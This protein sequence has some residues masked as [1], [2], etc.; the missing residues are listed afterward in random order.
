MR[1][2]ILLAA[3]GAAVPARADISDSGALTIGGQ[4]IIQGT[5][6]VQGA[7]FSIGGA[8]FSVAGGSVTLGGRLNLAASGIKWADGTTS[9]TAASGG[10]SSQVLLSSVVYYSGGYIDVSNTAYSVSYATV[11]LTADAGDYE[12][13]LYTYAINLSGATA[14]YCYTLRDGAFT[15]NQNGTTYATGMGFQLNEAGVRGNID[16]NVSAGSHS[17]SFGCAVNAGSGRLGY[18]GFNP[19]YNFIFGVRRIR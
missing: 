12:I 18:T 6:T 11:T 3:L 13:L 7:S 2:F 5:M 17:W 15:G 14:M 4:G 10:G 8:T 1:T 9:T 16:K 19:E